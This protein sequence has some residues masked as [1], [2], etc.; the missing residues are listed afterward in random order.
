ML[1]LPDN[2]VSKRLWS[3]KYPIYIEIIKSNSTHG[4][5]L[6]S[7][8]VTSKTSSV[9]GSD[10][11]VINVLL[12]ASL[13]ISG[14]NV[15]RVSQICRSKACPSIRRKHLKLPIFFHL[16]SGINPRWRKKCF[17]SLQGR[18]GTRRSGSGGSEPPPSDI[19]GLRGSATSPRT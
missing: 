17:T 7:R 6:R 4:T 11:Q 12:V 19:L 16:L 3:K 14:I 1:L 18:A 5:T 13:I 15:T 9:K 2:L 8:A 10:A